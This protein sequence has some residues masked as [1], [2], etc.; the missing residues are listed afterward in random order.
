[1]RIRNNNHFVFLLALVLGVLVA[2]YSRT[3]V[4]EY[5]AADLW[6]QAHPRDVSLG[7]VVTVAR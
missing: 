5:M 3:Y 7:R 2:F 1:M 4:G 6:S